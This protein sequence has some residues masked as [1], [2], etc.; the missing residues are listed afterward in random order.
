M[1]FV[2]KYC[3]QSLHRITSYLHNTSFV[4]YTYLEVPVP[5]V[6]ISPNHTTPLYVGTG[7]TLTCT[8]T[9]QSNMMSDVVITAEWSG[10]RDIPGERYTLTHS[11]LTGT[12]IAYKLIISPLRLQD[13]G[14]YTCAVKLTIGRQLSYDN[15]TVTINVLC[16]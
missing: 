3:R 1:G 9:I 11:N 7:L 8:A 10:P 4:L 13:S 2:V 12:V 14:L 6:S 15:M 5:Q 16:K